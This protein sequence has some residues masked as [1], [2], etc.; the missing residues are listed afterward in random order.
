[1]KSFSSKSNLFIFVHSTE[2]LYKT[3]LGEDYYLSAFLCRS[4]FLTMPCKK[5]ISSAFCVGYVYTF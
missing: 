5:G 3:F 2:K 1:M 4:K